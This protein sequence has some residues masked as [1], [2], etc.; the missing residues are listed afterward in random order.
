MTVIGST[1]QVFYS[2]NCTNRSTRVNIIHLRNH[3]IR[4]KPSTVP[5]R[6]C[7]TGNVDTS[8]R[9]NDKTHTYRSRA[10]H[11]KCLEIIRTKTSVITRGLQ[12]RRRDFSELILEK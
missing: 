11:D 2:E 7:P 6:R 10:A 12:S 3:T 4:S 1:G 8:E 9:N 5:K